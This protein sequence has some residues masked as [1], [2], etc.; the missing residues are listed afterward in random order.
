MMNSS[1]CPVNWKTEHESM[2]I[3]VF[4]YS[5]RVIVTHFVRQSLCTMARSSSSI[6][7]DRFDLA[8]RFMRFRINFSEC[9]RLIVDE[10][11]L[12]VL[13]GFWT[14]NLTNRSTAGDKERF[15]VIEWNSDVNGFAAAGEALVT[16]VVVGEAIDIIISS[17]S[18]N[19]RTKEKKITIQIYVRLLKRRCFAFKTKQSNN[20]FEKKCT[21]RRFFFSFKIKFVLDTSVAC[22][23]NRIDYRKLRRILW[24][25]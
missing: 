4:L 7:P 24:F 13:F 12:F 15:F 8:N 19:E 17:Q 6:E 1:T 9:S 2:A 21:K 14:H 10:L 5:H 25:E 22:L 11:E 23:Q 20:D 3:E 18:R 16:V